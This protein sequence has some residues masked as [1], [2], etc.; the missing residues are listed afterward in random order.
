MVHPLSRRRAC[1]VL[2][3]DLRYSGPRERR[4]RPARSLVPNLSRKIALLV[5][6]TIDQ[7]GCES[8]QSAVLLI[9]LVVGRWPSSPRRAR[10]VE[11]GAGTGIATVPLVEAGLNV[12]TVVLTPK[13]Y[14]FRVRCPQ[15]RQ[16]HG[17]W[18]HGTGAA[19]R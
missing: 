4:E 5:V 8:A 9:R 6:M 2:H 3:A 18:L 19:T 1:L 12:T 17:R 11:V 14:A 13:P 15:S 10:Y 7:L 16:R